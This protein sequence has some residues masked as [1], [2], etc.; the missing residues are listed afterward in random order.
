MKLD[1]VHR[2]MIRLRR[3]AKFVMKD[4]IRSELHCCENADLLDKPYLGAS[5]FMSNAAGIA[6]YS[7]RTGAKLDG[8]W[9]FVSQLGVF[10]VI[11]CVFFSFSPNFF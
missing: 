7:I 10:Q 4:E 5:K 8:D 9:Y 3:I 2:A 11:L 6:K 1:D